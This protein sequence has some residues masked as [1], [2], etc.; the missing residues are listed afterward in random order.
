MPTAVVQLPLRP[1]HGER[2]RLRRQL[3]EVAMERDAAA[4]LLREAIKQ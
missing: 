4:R 1:H 3:A 2:E